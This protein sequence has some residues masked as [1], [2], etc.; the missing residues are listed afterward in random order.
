L[1]LFG[2]TSLKSFCKFESCV[3]PIWRGTRRVK[4]KNVNKGT[5][6]QRRVEDVWKKKEKKTRNNIKENRGKCVILEQITCWV[7]STK[8]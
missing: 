2:W 4:E 7:S 8:Y 1:V 6:T 5:E 3:Y